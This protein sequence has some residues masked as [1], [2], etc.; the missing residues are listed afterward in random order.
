[1]YAGLA[2]TEPGQGIVIVWTIG[3][4]ECSLY[5]TPIRAGSLRV[6]GAEGERLTLATPSGA[7]FV[8]DVPRRKFVV[9]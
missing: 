9:P 7:T 8:F 3:R 2:K 4:N 1:V 5:R 6:V